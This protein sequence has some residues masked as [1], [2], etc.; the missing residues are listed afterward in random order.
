MMTKGRFIGDIT[1]FF[2]GMLIIALIPG[3]LSEQNKWWILLI[4]LGSSTLGGV[5]GGMVEKRR[6]K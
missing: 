4:L 3:F 2:I 6:K 1:G 5:V